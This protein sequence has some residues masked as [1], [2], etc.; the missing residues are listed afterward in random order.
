MKVRELIEF[1]TTYDQDKDVYMEEPWYSEGFL[2]CEV[3]EY[4]EVVL[5]TGQRVGGQ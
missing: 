3:Y 5:I 2:I 1:L 4:P